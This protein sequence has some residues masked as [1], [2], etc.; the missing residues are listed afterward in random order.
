MAKKIKINS[1]IR[2]LFSNKAI[3]ED[4]WAGM[5]DDTVDNTENKKSEYSYTGRYTSSNRGPLSA[6]ELEARKQALW[7]NIANKKKANLDNIYGK[8]NKSSLAT[9]IFKISPR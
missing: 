2:N 1:N 7:D 8:N 9:S 5:V 4:F 6:D 3:N